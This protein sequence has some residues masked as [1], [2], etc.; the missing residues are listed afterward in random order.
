MTQDPLRDLRIYF[1]VCATST[2]TRWKAHQADYITDI[3]G[4]RSSWSFT[5]IPNPRSMLGLSL[6][7]RNK[8][9]VH[10]VKITVLNWYKE[11]Q[12]WLTCRENDG[13]SISGYKKH[14]VYWL[15]WKIPNH[16]WRYY[17]QLSRH[18]RKSIKTKCSW[19]LMQRLLF[20]QENAPAYNALVAMAVVRVCMFGWLLPCSHDDVPFAY[21]L[22]SI[23]KIH[24]PRSDDYVKSAVYDIFRSRNKNRF[25]N[26]IQALQHR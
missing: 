21:H 22:F 9:T 11:G 24:F 26:G 17:A 18:L 3:V 20:Y 12:G 8:E 25:T 16:Q 6:W 14:C 13:L 4:S 2:D 5:M 23:M 7:V 15:S 1:T 19:K 10:T